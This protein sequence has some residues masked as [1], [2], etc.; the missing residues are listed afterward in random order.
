MVSL[1]KAIVAA[2][3]G[4]L[5]KWGTADAETRREMLSQ[6]EISAQCYCSVRRR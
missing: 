6:E 2:R 1:F 5:G 4:E 3:K